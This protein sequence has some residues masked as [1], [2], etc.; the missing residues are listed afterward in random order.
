MNKTFKFKCPRCGSYHAEKVEKCACIITTEVNI[1]YNTTEIIEI[2]PYMPPGMPCICDDDS[3]IV[4]RC[5]SCHLELDEDNI[6]EFFVEIDSNFKTL[7][8]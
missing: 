2:P 6:N 7:H 3:T 5:S 4:Y 8:F 1:R